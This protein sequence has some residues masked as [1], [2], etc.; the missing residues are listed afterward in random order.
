M[1]TKILILFLILSSA[2]SLAQGEA[3]IWYFG[4][5]AGL[6]FNSGNP[7]ALT[8]NQLNTGEGC[9]TLSNAAGQLL[10]YTDG[11]TI[12]NRNH[13]IMQNGTGL[14][15]HTES[16]QSATI[17]PKPGS[18]NLFYVFTI[19]YEARSNGFRYSIIDLNL[20]GGL[21]SVTSDKNI[22]IYTPTCE[23]IS[24]VK[25]ANNVDFW[26]VTHGW[27]NNNFYSHLLTST[28]LNTTPIISS[29]GVV[30]NNTFSTNSIGYM[31]ISPNGKKIAI[32]HSF[33]YLAQ[34]FDF[35]NISG[36]ITNPI[37]LTN[38]DF[39]Q[40]YGIEFS[41]NNEILYLTTSATKKLYQ[42]DLNAA[43][44]PSSI[45]LLQ[46]FNSSIGA[47]GALQIA[48]N[49]KIYIAQAGTNKLGVINNPNV[50]G[51]GCNVQ[52]DAFDLA[53]KICYSGFP[54][55][56]QSF[57]FSPEIVAENACVGQNAQF[58]LNTNQ[59]ILNASWDFGDGSPVQ[60]GITGNHIYTV[61]NTYTV[62]V[63]A[64]SA[65]GS[66]TK[67]T[68]ITI[69]NTP[70]AS[71]PLN[72]F[73][74]DDNNDGYFDF[75]LNSRKLA[76]LN[77]QDP[78][79]FNV[80]FFAT[81]SDYN[82]NI[83]IANPNIYQNEI[84]YQEE[85]I[86]AEVYN[87]QNGDCKA[88]TT[89]LI[90]VM[91]TPQP[92]TNVTPINSCD[93]TSFGT[94]VDGRV[95]FNLTQRA[96]AILNGQSASQFTL[97][98][99]QD[100]ALTMPIAS[101]TNYVNTNT[102]ETIYVKVVNNDNANCVATTSFTIEVLP[103]PV[104]TNVVTLKQCD[105]NIDG[106][107]VFNLTEANRQISSNFA[108][109]I[110]TYFE[111]A[112]EAQNNTN[113]IANPT[114]YTNQV[115]SND[116]VFVRVVNANGCFRVATLNLNVSTTQ[117]PPNFP[118][119][120]FTVCDDAILGTNTDGISSFD[121]SNVT[122]QIQNLFPVGQQLV[123]TYY[124]N[125]ADALAERN[126]ITDTANYRNIG[127]P[128]TQ[129]IYI[130]VDSAVNNDCLGLGQHITL[131]VERIPIVQPQQYQHCDDDQDGIYG[132]DTSNLQS[133]L[134]NGLTGVAVTYL[135]A[136]NNPLPS[137]LP[138]PFATTTQTIKAVVTNTT[139]TACNYQTTIDFKVDDLPEAFPINVNLTTVCDDEPVPTN[140]DGKYA[141]D[142]SSFQSTIV[143]SQ[144]GML[145]NYYDQ[146]NNPLPSPLPNPFV[147]ATQNVRVEVMN[148][149]NTTCK[150]IYTIP[151]VVHPV[152]KIELNGNEIV[153]NQQTLTKKLEA[154]IVDGTP[155]SDYTYAWK[156]NSD[157][158]I[159]GTNA[160]LDITQEG[161]YTVEVT[162]SFQCSRTRTI[163]VVASDLATIASVQ[164]SDLS[165][166]N[167]IVVSVTG[168]GDYVYSLNN[169][170]FQTSNTFTDVPAGVYNVYV[171][172]LNGCGTTPPYE[173]SVLGIPSYFTPNGDGYHDYWNIKGIQ[174]ASNSDT[175]I[176]IFDRFGKLLQKLDPSSPGWNGTYQNQNLPATD[177]WYSVTLKDGRVLKGHFALKR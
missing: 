81:L 57:F 142:T 49:N 123:I 38:N 25:H 175:Q 172:D 177:Y 100:A 7:V 53:G 32:C 131:Q 39:G 13:Q 137:P 21:G 14:M 95:R 119:R 171:K 41:P 148:P 90:D 1:K 20:D 65:L 94:D 62:T 152:P 169:I 96:I 37:T 113:P 22:P 120:T 72:M 19:D 140:Q 129:N 15:G 164:V 108:N 114:T 56:N 18:S 88:T 112:T 133:T 115:V 48:P 163:M 59:T 101:P 31:K 155:T 98:Y 66:S 121:F 16:T 153:C 26:I 158:T 130:R 82:N 69:Y 68:N 83:P 45:L 167:T 6:D 34:L 27:N 75:N 40:L 43:N 110:F 70:T 12:Y 36:L 111:T 151:F 79:I 149:I 147:T 30:V 42:F 11:T 51:G 145:V 54:A 46:I 161:T 166:N 2:T 138:N 157:P 58:S 61:P 118:Q 91:D 170:D 24:I 23:K 73:A 109:E 143:G 87:T 135:D 93:N 97:S 141:F 9:A 124:R 125:L 86:I 139:P 165:N 84:S 29:T 28:G 47:L 10:F 3:N 63:T 74:C 67:T 156:R 35:D 132:F 106:F 102:V 33:L 134:L 159:L 173:V 77:G 64:T 44:I 89:F 105:D 92:A 17:V 78:S 71:Q 85:T 107:S 144:T 104:I 8:N 50:L 76:I 174:T 160:T 150:A 117:I 52:M 136:N 5:H 176:F 80:R 116:V 162:N 127:Y 146:N 168:T 99:F 60:N 126:A 4:N 128:N 154:G 103:L 122:S 55:F